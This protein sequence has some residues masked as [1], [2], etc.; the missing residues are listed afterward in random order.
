VYKCVLSQGIVYI[1]H[2]VPETGSR[3]RT[4]IM[5]YCLPLA[6][7]RIILSAVLHSYYRECDKKIL[8]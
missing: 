3:G 7:G 5:I 4:Y 6:I 8:S 2:V 1:S